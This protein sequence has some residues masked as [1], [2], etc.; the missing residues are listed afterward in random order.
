L[1]DHLRAHPL[2][3]IHVA[4]GV[5]ALVLGAA[6]ILSRKGTPRHRWIGRGYLLALLALN[7]TSLAIYE[8]FGRLGPFHWLAMVSLATLAG[9]Y[10]AALRKAPGWMP[11]HAYFMC[12]SYVGLAAASVVEVASRVPGW[13]FG[14]S[15][16]L[17]SLVVIALGGWMMWSSVP[18]I[19]GRLV[20]P[21]S[22]PSA[23]DSTR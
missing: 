14:R 20:S 7:G 13:S 9:G 23:G 18:R 17:S 19:A 4:S 11:R 21:S 15:V 16:V 2:G 6:V 10:L 3:L 1:L 22:T 5:A 12:G 8:V